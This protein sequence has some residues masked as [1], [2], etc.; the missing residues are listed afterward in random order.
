MRLSSKVSLTIIP[1]I[2]VPLLLVGAY[3]YYVLWQKNINS[4]HAQLEYYIDHMKSNYKEAITGAT[5][6]LKTLASDSLMKQYLLTENEVDR[7]A[8]MQRPM[9]AKLTTIQIA[10]PD[11][12]EIRLLLPDGYEELRVTNRTIVNVTDDESSSPFFLELGEKQADFY[13]FAGISRDTGEH[14]IYISIPIVLRDRI[15]DTFTTEPK[16]RGYL[17]ATL[18]LKHLLFEKIPEPWDLG[19]TLL[20]SH[21]QI[22]KYNSAD[23]LPLSEE[24]LLS[25]LSALPLNRWNSITIND[26][27]AQ[28]FAV[29]LTDGLAFHT[30]IPNKILLTSSLSISNFILGIAVLMLGVTIPLILRFFRRQILLPINN[31]NLALHKLKAGGEMPYL[32][33]ASSCEINQLI[34][35][36]NH[37]NSELTRSSKK[38]RNLAY[39]DSLTGLPNRTL[40]H[41]NLMRA[42]DH[43]DHDDEILALLYLD[44]DNFKFVN[45]NMG[46]TV[47]GHSSANCRQYFKGN[48]ADRRYGYASG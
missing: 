20:S 36:F 14:V 21:N 38:I 43:A 27:R 40:F 6:T 37:M 47:G 9:L 5:I 42:I 8:L 48:P 13:H 29:E 26:T 32:E 23:A 1:L 11:L 35:S 25:Q 4:S 15:R 2:M 7:Y 16:L 12:F 3:S 45:D 10:S 24:M 46:H 33:Q 22:F 18:E 31:L 19:T 34:N 17:S 41:R 39:I 30:Y 44:L 28:H